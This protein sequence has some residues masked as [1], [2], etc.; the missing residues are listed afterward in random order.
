MI[1]TRIQ[2][3]NGW[4]FKQQ[5]WP[6]EAWLPVSQA[7][8]Q[9]HMDL[10]AHKK[11][12]DPFVDM[13]ERAVQ[14]IGEKVWQYRVSFP[15][16]KASSASAVTDL[17]FEGLDT[18]ATVLLNGREILKTDN[19]F[20]SYRVNINEHIKPDGNNILEIVFDSALIRGREIVKEHSHEHSFLVRQT[21]AGRVA[22]RKAQYN[23][24]WDWGPIIMTAGPWKPVYLEQYTARVDD[25][26]AQNEL[27][28]DLEAV[29]GTIYTNV[30][31]DFH[32][33][34]RL[35]ISLTLEGRKVLEELAPVP[36]NGKYAVPFKIANPQLWYPRSYG[37]Q[38]RYKL[39]ASI[40]RS[41]AELHSTSKLIGFRRAELIQEPDAHGKSFYFRINNVDVFGGGSCWIPA[42]SYLSQISPARYHD[43]IKLMAE[44]NQ[45]MVRVWGGGIYEDD[46]FLDA[47][48]E[49]G[50]LI[51]HD[52][53]FACASYPTYPSYMKT[54]EMEVRQQL[55]R[56]R[57]H[58]AVVAWAGNNEDYQVQE[59]YRLDYDFEN[60]DLESWLKST[61]PARY[62]YEHFLPELV[63]QED[64]FMIYHPSSPWGDGKP[65]ADPTVG[66]IHQWNLWHGAVN[67]YQEVSLLGGRFVSEFGM[68]AYPHLSTVRR[69]TTHSSQL[70]PGSM[71]ID[72]HNKGIFNERRMTTYVSEN[73]RLK[74]DL[75]SYIHLTQVVQAEAMR[76]AY[77][78]WRR[79][80]G[81]SGDRK[82]GG[83]LVWQ[84]ND[85][86]PTMSW[87]VVDYYLVKKPA[88]YAI[89]RAL[90]PL[91]VGVS[92]TYH[93]WT[94]T[95]YYI[96][97]NSQLCTGQVDQTLPAR[98]STFDVW[99]ASSKV[100]AVNAKV[101]V[102]F[103]SIRSG[104]D[105]SESITA[106]VSASA[107]ATTTVFSSKPL[108]PSIPHH[109][110]YTIPFDVTQYDPY[111]VYTTLS[112]DGAV[113][114]TDAA[115]PDP[116]KF[117]DLSNRGISFAISENRVTVSS[118]RPVKGFVFEEV[119]G[120]K[121]SDNGFDIMP[122]E[123]HVV[124]VE[125]PV[126]A[127]K[128][129]WTHIGADDASM[130]INT[131]R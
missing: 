83:V 15:A 73:F 71:T 76:A 26:W 56:L 39:Q 9:I 21:E 7:P 16:P 119:Q 3:T 89:S 32:P 113:V 57:C 97:E 23:W 120:M 20:V 53:Q 58:P 124:A 33:D 130:E 77:K 68:E 31:G 110:D 90:R 8:S 35:A 36:R 6:S 65:T 88:Y 22:V 45:V 28:S 121:L 74:Y 112:I 122:G 126:S 109:D 82:C 102:R 63:K 118:D 5:E 44:G 25:V 55:R 98:E 80:W 111:V 96:D 12:P 43:W 125:G 66:D 100:Q 49:F 59:R 107:N 38:T 116:I 70:Y 62:I 108:K 69:M 27:D 41:G 79:D 84:L 61:F 128:L 14:W 29:T 1:Y 92:R 106:S 117:L 17:V 60:K 13:N 51:W 54:L 87:A 40:V 75:P 123:K 114:A 47:C 115:W 19:M 101:T 11:I 4:T 81:T 78:T 129:R 48:D 104:R 72:F 93:D 10:L 85:C 99:I 64:P 86:W 127:D 95:G 18:F 94:Q 34:D 52:F 103:I 91:D 46:T 50:V 37:K 42:D 67:K 24:G 105:V 131:R 30:V 2:L